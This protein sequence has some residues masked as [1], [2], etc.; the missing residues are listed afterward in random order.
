MTKKIVY[1]SL[2]LS[3]F[4]PF[5]Y[6]GRVWAKELKATC[7]DSS[8]QP[9]TEDGFFSLD[10]LSPGQTYSFQ[11]RFVN[12]S[13]DRESIYFSLNPEAANPQGGIEFILK[14]GDLVL[15]DGYLTKKEVLNLGSLDSHKTKDFW[16][17]LKTPANLDDDWQGKS[18]KFDSNLNFEIGNSNSSSSVSTGTSPTPTPAPTST[19]TKTK[20]S[21]RRKKKSG[22]GVPSAFKGK[23]PSNFRPGQVLGAKSDRDI[24]A[25]STT[26]IRNH[27]IPWIKAHPIHSLLIIFSL[28]LVT[29]LLRVVWTKWF[30]KLK[31]K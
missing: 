21:H 14:D 24:L 1:I 18:F 12:D 23:L 10:N 6:P 27:F 3:L 17:F 29:I 13:N 7:S 8:C 9:A 28:G 26:K 15:Y 19:P 4:F 16:L 22:L 30:S 11:L 2:L 5:F 25:A 31:R 20:T